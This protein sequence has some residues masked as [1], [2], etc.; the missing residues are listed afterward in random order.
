VNG[1][2]EEKRISEWKEIHAIA[3]QEALI[4]EIFENPEGLC[5][6]M[7]IHEHTQ[8]L[9]LHLLDMARV[10]QRSI[11]YSIKAYKLG[12][13]EFCTN[14]RDNTYEVNI[15]HREITE[16]A[17]DL[18]LMDMPSESDLR[19]VLSS[20][21]ICNALQ[22]MHRQA[23][24]IVA[25][26]MGFLET[27]GKLKCTDLATMGDVVNSLVR[28]CVVALFEEGIEH[29]ETVLL[30]DGVE[31][32]FEMTFYDWYRTIDQRAR[33][34]AGHE[35]AITKHLSQIAQQTHEIADAIVFW[36]EGTTRQSLHGASKKLLRRETTLVAKGEADTTDSSGMQSFLQSIEICFAD[37]RFWSRL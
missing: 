1:Y 11:D 5:N 7:D 27:R 18:L 17:Q 20:P 36:L 24:E 33:T 9:R 30:T 35:L 15:L 19:F 13:S 31:R 6:S 25:N 23:V 29:A 10:S 2:A 22:A 16:I 3:T 21:R 14:V 8:T 4:A 12:G 34:Q 28:L 37:G 32:L 26:S